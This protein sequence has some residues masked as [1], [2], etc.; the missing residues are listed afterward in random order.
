MKAEGGQPGAAMGTVGFIDMG[1]APIQKG[2][3]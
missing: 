2:K 1:K 3:S